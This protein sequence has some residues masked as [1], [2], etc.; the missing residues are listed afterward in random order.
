MTIVFK[1]IAFTQHCVN[2]IIMHSFFYLGII[3]IKNSSNRTSKFL[4]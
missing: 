4:L 3:L 2:D 1:K